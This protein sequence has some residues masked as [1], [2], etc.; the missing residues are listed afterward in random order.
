MKYPGTES[1]MRR[2][3]GTA[4]S[5]SPEELLAARNATLGT[6]GRHQAGK[7][8]ILLPINHVTTGKREIPFC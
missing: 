1:T 7:Q 5:A 4:L 8:H 3:G 2:P 6:A